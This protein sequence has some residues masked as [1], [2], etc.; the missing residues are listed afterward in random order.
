MFLIKDV[1]DIKKIEISSP[2]S[3]SIKRLLYQLHSIA[4]EGEA[5]GPPSQLIKRL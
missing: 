2:P 1:E 5:V 3:Q 4:T